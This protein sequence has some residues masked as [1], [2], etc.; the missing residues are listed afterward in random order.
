[1]ICE[2]EQ[3]N[4]CPRSNYQAGY[5]AVWGSWELAIELKQS[6][7]TYSKYFTKKK[8]KYEGKWTIYG[9]TKCSKQ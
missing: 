6:Y 9:S 8:S 1:M 7:S 4:M 2:H 3:M 5:A